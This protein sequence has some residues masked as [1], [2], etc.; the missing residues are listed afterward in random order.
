M[1]NVLHKKSWRTGAVQIHM[2]P[3]PVTIIKSKND[4]QAG[5]DGVKKYRR[6]PTS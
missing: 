6:D 4:M 1:K 3:P 2:K 5:K